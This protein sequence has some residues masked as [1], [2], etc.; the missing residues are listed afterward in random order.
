MKP[1]TARSGGEMSSEMKQ[2][3]NKAVENFQSAI[4]H[5]EKI[6]YHPHD[7]DV[8]SCSALRL[9]ILKTDIEKIASMLSTRYKADGQITQLIQLYNTQLSLNSC[10]EVINDSIRSSALSDDVEMLKS[11]IFLLENLI[12]KIT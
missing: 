11:E 7:L 10:I 9:Q 8:Y 6:I 3:F 4:M 1:H 2:L 12:R 5:L